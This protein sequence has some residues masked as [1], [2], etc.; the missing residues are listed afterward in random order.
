[1]LIVSD[2]FTCVCMKK[3]G[4]VYL[5]DALVWAFWSQEM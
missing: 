3:D 1:M 2:G 5:K 4:D